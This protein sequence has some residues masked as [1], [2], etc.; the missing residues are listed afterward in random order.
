[1]CLIELQ[2]SVLFEVNGCVH[3]TGEALLLGMREALVKQG[4]IAMRDLDASALSK[5]NSWRL[6]N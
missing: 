1:M 2:L 6:L 4:R 3:V 5:L